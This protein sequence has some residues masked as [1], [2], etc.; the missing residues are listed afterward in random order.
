[1]DGECPNCARC[2]AERR[3]AVDQRDKLRDLVS[4]TSDYLFAIEAPLLEEEADAIAA[5]MR[6]KLSEVFQE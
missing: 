4:R 5:S 1:M 3:K 6:I 2:E